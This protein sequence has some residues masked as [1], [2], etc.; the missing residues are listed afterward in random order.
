MNLST[1]YMGLTLKNPILVSASSLSR[2]LENIKECED[3]GAAGVVL[4]SLFEEQIRQD[5]AYLLGNHQSSWL[6]SF[7]TDDCNLSS[8]HMESY[9][10]LIEQAS[11][12]VDI[13]IVGSLNGTTNAGWVECAKSIE[14]AG[15]KALELNIFFIPTDL[16]ISGAEIEQ[17]YLSILKEVKSTVSIP[18]SLKLSPFFSAMGNIAKRFDDEGANGLVMFNRFYQPDFDINNLALLSTLQ[19]STPQEIRLPLLWIAILYGKLK[20]SLA[21]TTGVHSA[22]E[23]VKY[24]LAG[25]DVVM[26]ASAIFKNGY[27]I[28]KIMQFGLERW[29]EQHGYESVNQIRGLMSQQ[30]QQDPSIYERV[31]YLKVIKSLKEIDL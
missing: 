23:I 28:I 31:N 27:E 7:N 11:R 13:P 16:S 20:A 15:A 24:L 30:Q 26:T 19:L 14:Q 6:P 18:V 8:S 9:L 22:N 17:R 2:K 12:A 1:Q 10:S 3:A 21:A 4:F 5:I 29:L 25:A